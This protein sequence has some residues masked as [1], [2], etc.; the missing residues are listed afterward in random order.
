MII[1][2]KMTITDKLS[3]DD[4]QGNGDADEKDRTKFNESRTS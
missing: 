4:F 3:R 1:T 2:D